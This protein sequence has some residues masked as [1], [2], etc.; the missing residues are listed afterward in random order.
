MITQSA[1]IDK[2][3]QDLQ[4][5][6]GMTIVKR[7]ADYKPPPR[8]ATGLDGLDALLGGGLV[9][10]GMTLF[11]GNTTSGRV[12]LAHRIMAN[13]KGVKVWF[14]RWGNFDPESARK[15]GVDLEHLV[16]VRPRDARNGRESVE[17]LGA[18]INLHI[19]LIVLDDGTSSEPIELPA[20]V[21]TQ[22]AQSGSVLLA[23]PPIRQLISR[24]AAR[25]IVEREETLRRPV[26]GEVIGFHSRLTVIEQ[27]G[28]RG[29][30]HTEMDILLEDA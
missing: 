6:F 23:L 27:P 28:V 18:L 13:E 17:L 24:S 22:L 30:S 2:V 9:T 4:E 8:Y 29:H 21:I 19:P 5:R 10:G 11:Q 15:C 3:V 16:I 14:D 7:L 26:T 20:F 12:T 1:G 25:L